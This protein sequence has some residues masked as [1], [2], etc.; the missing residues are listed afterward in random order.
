MCFTREWMLP[1][2]PTFGL[3]SAEQTGS[4]GQSGLRG[5]PFALIHSWRSVAGSVVLAPGPRLYDRGPALGRRE[6]KRCRR[7]ALIVERIDEWFQVPD[8][9]RDHTQD[10][11]VLARHPM[12]LEDI[13]VG[14]S[15][16]CDPIGLQLAGTGNVNESLNRIS[17]CNGVDAGTVAR[18]HPVPLQTSH[19]ASD[20]RG[21][22]PYVPRELSVSEARIILQQPQQFP[23]H[24][25]QSHHVSNSSRSAFQTDI[26]WLEN[27]TS[28]IPRT[29]A[30]FLD[31]M[32]CWNNLPWQPGRCSVKASSWGLFALVSLLWGVPYLF[33]EIALRDIGPLSTAAARVAIAALVM[34]PFLLHRQ[35]WRVL[36]KRW[37]ALLVLAVVEVVV[38]LSLITVGQLSVPSGTTGV[39]IATEPLF[40]AILAPLLF[41]KPWL[42]PLGWLGLV[43]G[44][45]GVTTLLGLDG[46]GPGVLLIAGAALAYGLGA[47]LIDHWFSEYDALTVAA[48]MILTAA[49]LLIAI[50]VAAEPIRVPSDT[51]VFALIMLGVACTAGGFS[52]FF[53]LIKRAGPT[54]AALTTYTA[55]IIAVVA[56]V[57]VLRENLTLWQVLSCSLILVGAAFIVRPRGRSGRRPAKMSPAE[58]CSIKL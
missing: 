19:S 52:A 55:P 11:I 49:P 14:D 3:G 35:R 20:R 50:A 9:L 58:Q 31:W 29:S 39:I 8:G 18:Y 27:F 38:P 26:L 16:V 10:V 15:L 17:S 40:I 33:I 24:V 37:R 22:Q 53:A 6:D 7:A 42:S 21:A 47:I 13:R 25:I 23:V 28:C 12:I 1:P 41:R 34:G 44:L 2:S 36:T 43:L 56:G 5:V 54:T 48:A 46:A 4:T 45:I 30:F 32:P 51:T 57:L